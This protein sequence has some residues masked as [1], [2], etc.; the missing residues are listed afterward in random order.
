MENERRATRGDYHLHS[1]RFAGRLL[2]NRETGSWQPGG[3]VD[4]HFVDYNRVGL[5]HA[6]GRPNPGRGAA[7]EN[8]IRVGGIEV[9]FVIPD[10]TRVTAVEAIE[11]EQALPQEIRFKVAENRVRFSMPVFRVYS[12]ARIKLAPRPAADT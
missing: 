6:D 2:G 8:P 9:D 11:P 3:E 12:V 1:N 7:D 10:E 5:P 4:L